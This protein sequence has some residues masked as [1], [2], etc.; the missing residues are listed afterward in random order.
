MAA[1]LY[2]KVFDAHIVERLDGDLYQLFVGLHFVNDVTSAQAFAGLRER[3]LDVM[4][5]DRTVSTFDH[6]I[7]GDSAAR[8][9]WYRPDHGNV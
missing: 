6:M 1:T 7:P 3:N 8:H 4:F 2:D 5:P 9:T